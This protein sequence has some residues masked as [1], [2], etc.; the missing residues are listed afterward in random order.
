MKKFNSILAIAAVALTSV[1][2]FTSCDKNDDE[3]SQS[4]TPR[5]QM[6]QQDEQ[7]PGQLMATLEYEYSADALD[8]FE[9]KY[10][11]KDFSGNVETFVVTEPGAKKMTLKT[12]D[13]H[14]MASV[15]AV[16]TPKE[17]IEEVEGKLYNF[18]IYSRV[19]AWVGDEA[20]MYGIVGVKNNIALGN[21]WHLYDVNYQDIAKIQ[22]LYSETYEVVVKI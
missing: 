16:L 10:E 7:V 9:V 17:N 14:G 13:L 3:L 5:T 1:F 21:K 2:G 11:I 6:E 15:K 20:S 19:N 12:D 8:A 4:A 18:T 22:D